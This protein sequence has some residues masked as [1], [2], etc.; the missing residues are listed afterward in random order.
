MSMFD[1]TSNRLSLNWVLNVLGLGESG[2]VTTA[3]PGAFS[4][5]SSIGNVDIVLGIISCSASSAH[6]NIKTWHSQDYLFV[7]IKE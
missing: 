7:S 5:L 3:L 2:N 6:C 4:I 1:C